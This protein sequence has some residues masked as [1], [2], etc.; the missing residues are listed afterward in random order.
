M[1]ASLTEFSSAKETREL[2][3]HLATNISFQEI[4]ERSVPATTNLL[5]NSNEPFVDTIDLV[6]L[7]GDPI[8]ERIF[9]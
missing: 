5:A 2:I 4:G 3:S 8:S 7:I 6:R 1:E 9:R